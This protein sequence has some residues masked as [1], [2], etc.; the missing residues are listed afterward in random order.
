MQYFFRFVE[1]SPAGTVCNPDDAPC[2]GGFARLTTMVREAFQR[3][4]Q[5]LLL[6]G[7]DSFQ[8]TIWYN[9][10]RWNVTQDFMNILDHDAHVSLFYSFY[11]GLV[12]L[13][14]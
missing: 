4:P 7:G 3:E 1:T 8:G 11:S 6:N 5:S 14:V 9:L 12:Q 2:V 13:L 10:L